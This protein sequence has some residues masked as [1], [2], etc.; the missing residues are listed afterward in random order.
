MLT[1]PA[2]HPDWKYKVWRDADILDRRWKNQRLV[3]EYASRG[4]WRGVADV[5]RYEILHE[6]GGFMP[7]ADSE[8]LRPCDELFTDPRHF[9]YAV[10]EN[11]RVRPGLITPLY[12]ALPHTQFAE[13]L[14][15]GLL[16]QTSGEPWKHTGNR[17]MQKVYGARAW[18][19]VKVWPSHYFNPEH[20]SGDVYNG[21][22]KPY[23]R[24]HWGSTK[25]AY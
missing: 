11:E 1:W 15:W 13:A 5:V 22:D 20:Y 10:Y 4:E 23:A 24:Q 25:G 14:I 18:Q 12:A 6:V 8:C 21:P 3:D 19:T 2:H 9:A 16:Y 7:G 17:H